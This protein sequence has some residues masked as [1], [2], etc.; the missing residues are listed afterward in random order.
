MINRV[1]RNHVVLSVRPD[2]IAPNINSVEDVFDLVAVQD[3]AI[4]LRG[5][6]AITGRDGG[7]D[8][9]LVRCFRPPREG[10]GR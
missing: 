9:R 8:D 2:L 4:V 5:N 1:I 10:A 7:V 3:E 6:D